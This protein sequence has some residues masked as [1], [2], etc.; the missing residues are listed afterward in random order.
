M[1][2]RISISIDVDL[3]KEIFDYHQK[4]KKPEFGEKGLNIS[5]TYDEIIKKGW[6]A[7]KK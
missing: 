2:V 4:R 5:N 6:K 1:K 3:A 7:T